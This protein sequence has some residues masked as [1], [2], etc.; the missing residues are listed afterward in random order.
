MISDENNYKYHLEFEEIIIRLKLVIQY[1]KY[2]YQQIECSIS[3]P[4][5]NFFLK[6]ETSLLR[7]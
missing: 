6:I 1:L 7:K 5:F 4:Q 3:H 2:E